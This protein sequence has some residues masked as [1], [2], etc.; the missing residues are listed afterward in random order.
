MNFETGEGARVC[1]QKSRGEL[2]RS[3][4]L[5]ILGDC[6]TGDKDCIE[7]C[8]R[9]NPAKILG[10][11]LPEFIGR[12]PMADKIDEIE[13]AEADLLSRLDKS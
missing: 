13:A 2:A 11:N 1:P 7:G 3:N 12:C 9:L 10:I 6:K 4:F 8:P 5:W